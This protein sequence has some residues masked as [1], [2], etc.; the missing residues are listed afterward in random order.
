MWE[1]KLSEIMETK[2]PKVLNLTGKSATSRD[3]PRCKIGIV[4]RV[5]GI[6]KIERDTARRDRADLAMN[7]KPNRIETGNRD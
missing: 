1:P 3:P 2:L 7:S 5:G 6:F 4:A